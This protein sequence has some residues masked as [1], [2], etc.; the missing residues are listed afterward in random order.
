MGYMLWLAP[1]IIV[2]ALVS[3]LVLTYIGA[4]KS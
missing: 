1:T 3:W 2:I 4:R